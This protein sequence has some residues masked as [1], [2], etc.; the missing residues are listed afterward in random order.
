MSSSSSSSLSTTMTDTYDYALFDRQEEQHLEYLKDRTK[1][2]KE[3]YDSIIMYTGY[4]SDWTKL[5]DFLRSPTLTRYS[6]LLKKYK[7][8]KNIFT[9]LY[10][11]NKVILDAP[12]LDEDIVLY[13]GAGEFRYNF[14]SDS[15]VSVIENSIISTSF[16]SSIAE[17][18]NASGNKIQCFKLSAGTPMLNINGLSKTKESTNEYEIILPAGSVLE[19]IHEDEKYVYMNVSSVFEDIHTLSKYSIENMIQMDDSILNTNIKQAFQTNLSIIKRIPEKMDE[20]GN[21]ILNNVIK[22]LQRILGEEILRN[23]VVITKIQN[24]IIPY[25][26]GLLGNTFSKLRESSDENKRNL[27]DVYMRL[28]DYV[29]YKLGSKI[30]EMSGKRNKKTNKKKHNKRIRRNKTSKRNKKGK[31]VMKK[32]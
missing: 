14:G 15:G 30:V 5:A 19:Y 22:V 4:D 13:R 32:A 2:S 1:V 12:R 31:K 3:H 6:R 8:H 7:T 28:I 23:P 16:V 27:F 29:G 9:T 10:N 24:D 26:K 17:S 18:F 21:M 20:K 25:V 11:I